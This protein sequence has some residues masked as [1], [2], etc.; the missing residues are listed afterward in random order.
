MPGEKAAIKVRLRAG[1]RLVFIQFPLTGSWVRSRLE[2]PR[3]GKRGYEE[4]DERNAW[5]NEVS[6]K[7]SYIGN[8]ILI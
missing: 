6:Y 5:K 1:G 2:R 4:N 3:W 8:I 7:I